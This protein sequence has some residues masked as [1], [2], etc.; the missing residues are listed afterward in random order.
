M[1]Q[2][3]EELG[4]EKTQNTDGQVTLTRR[5]NISSPKDGREGGVRDNDQF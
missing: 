2:R 3:P 4:E 5:E 1:D